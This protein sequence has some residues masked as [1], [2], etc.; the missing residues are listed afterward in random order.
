MRI[1]KIYEGSDLLLSPSFSKFYDTY[2]DLVIFLKVLEKNGAVPEFVKEKARELIK[3][4]EASRKLVLQNEAE[5]DESDE[6]EVV[7]VFSVI[8]GASES[9]IKRAMADVYGLDDYEDVKAMPVSERQKK[10]KELIKMLCLTYGPGNRGENLEFFDTIWET[11]KKQNGINEAGPVEIAQGI[12]LA[13]AIKGLLG[14]ALGAIAFFAKEYLDKRERHQFKL[15]RL[16]Y[17]EDEINGLNGKRTL[18][19]EQIG[20][21]IRELRYYFG[22]IKVSG[23]EKA[24]IDEILERAE[25][26]L[27]ELKNK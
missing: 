14:I 8:S 2:N 22:K 12:L 4:A 1:R 16:K 15:Y 25:D 24:R 9:E 27:E 13:G 18:N 17:L 19:Q 26:L 20:S 7:K 10:M 21:W 11:L 3:E 6:E 5:L 23:S